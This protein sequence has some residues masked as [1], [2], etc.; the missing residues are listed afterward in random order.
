[1]YR[2]YKLCSPGLE[3]IKRIYLS[4]MTKPALMAFSNIEAIN[5]YFNTKLTVFAMFSY[6]F[7]VWLTYFPMYMDYKTRLFAF[8]HSIVAMVIIR[9]Q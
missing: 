3:E 2:V 7:N 9:E 6:R 8:P 5:F 1:M 4:T